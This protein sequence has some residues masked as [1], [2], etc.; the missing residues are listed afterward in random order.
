MAT[1]AMHLHFRTL[2]IIRITIIPC[3]GCCAGCISWSATRRPSSKALITA[4]QSNISTAI[5]M[6]FASASHAALSLPRCFSGFLWPLPGRRLTERDNHKEKLIVRTKY[7]LK[8]RNIY[9]LDLLIRWSLCLQM[10]SYFICETDGLSLHITAA[11]LVI[12][13]AILFVWSSKITMKSV[14][15]I[16]WVILLAFQVG[17]AE[18]IP[19]Q[20]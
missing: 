2:N 15:K 17:W 18:D 14:C 20:W 19:E 9:C 6:S 5:L 16:L 3:M 4:C 10:W 7:W 13:C 1:E 12:A 8:K 11:Q